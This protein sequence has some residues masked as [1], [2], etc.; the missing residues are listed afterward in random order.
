M[1]IPSFR[2]SINREVSILPL[3]MHNSQRFELE[4]EEFNLNDIRL[5]AIWGPGHSTQKI[6]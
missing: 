5:D 4:R 1:R 3:E 6:L 2:L